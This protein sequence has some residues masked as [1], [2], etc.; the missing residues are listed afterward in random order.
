MSAVGRVVHDEAGE[1][2]SQLTMAGVAV[3]DS[4]DEEAKAH[5]SRMA[6]SCQHLFGNRECFFSILP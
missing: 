1:L 6:V 5:V 4:R 2:T 3:S